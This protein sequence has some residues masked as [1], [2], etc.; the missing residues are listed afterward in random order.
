MMQQEIQPANN[1]QRFEQWLSSQVAERGAVPLDDIAYQGEQLGLGERTRRKIK[2]KLG[3][4]TIKPQ[5]EG[6]CWGRPAVAVTPSLD[7]LPAAPMPTLVEAT[8]LDDN[9]T[10][11]DYLKAMQQLLK[12]GDS[13]GWAWGRFYLAAEAS[14]Y[15]DEITEQMQSPDWTGPKLKTL[16]NYAAI[17]RRVTPGYEVE[18]ASIHHYAVT[19]SLTPDQQRKLVKE[20]IKRHWPISV[21]K[22][23]AADILALEK[24]T[25]SDTGVSAEPL[26]ELD[27]DPESAD[28][29]R[30]PDVGTAADPKPYDRVM[31]LLAEANKLLGDAEIGDALRADGTA[32]NKIGRMDNLLTLIGEL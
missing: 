20:A 9:A 16:K 26:V 11:A 15:G 18:G 21:L 32:L 4:E 17:C 25:P 13:L 30:R 6:F 29:G 10:L 1:K 14:G 28:D 2:T 7:Q 31:M 27:D 24:Q 12:A 5:G 19:I 8:A 3:L 23:K 22:N